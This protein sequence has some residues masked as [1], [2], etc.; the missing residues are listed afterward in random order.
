MATTHAA[1]KAHRATAMFAYQLKSK[2]K[3]TNG[4]KESQWMNMYDSGELEIS[5]VF[6][7][8][9][10]HVRN[11][12]GKPTVKV[13]EDTHDFASINSAGVLVPLGD[14][15]VAS[16]QKDGYKRRYMINKTYN[17]EGNIYAVCWNWMTNKLAFFVMPPDDYDGYCHPKQ[18]YKIMCCPD[19]GKRTKG[20]YNENCH[21]NTF[22]E[23]CLVD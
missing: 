15:K 9:L 22:E 8:L 12:Y 23:M 21:Y 6:E 5:S 1:I 10:V 20:W 7:N 11:L 4:I 19:T 16:L 3:I 17:K 13:L 2:Y 14:F 18:G